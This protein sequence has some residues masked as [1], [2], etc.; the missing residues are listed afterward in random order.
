MD[1][2]KI[3][4]FQS[5]EDDDQKDREFFEDD[6]DL[7][8]G[9]TPN[10]QATMGGFG[11]FGPAFDEIFRQNANKRGSNYGG[12]DNTGG[13]GGPPPSGGAP[14]R[15][16]NKKNNKKVVIALILLAISVGFGL[17]LQYYVDFQWFR[18]LDFQEIFIKQIVIQVVAA[19]GVFI[20]G[21]LL[22]L[23]IA[24]LFFKKNIVAGGMAKKTFR[25]IALAGSAVAGFLA[26]SV[27][28]G[29]FS[30]QLLLFLNGSSFQEID[31]I[32]NQD[33]SFYVFTL[34]FMQQIYNILLML[35][36]LYLVAG[37]VVYFKNALTS[38]AKDAFSPQL[39]TLAGFFSILWG[40]GYWFRM[41]DLLYGSGGVVFGATYTDIH[42]SLPF[43]RIMT[44]AMIGLG[45]F[46]IV[47]KNFKILK[48]AFIGFVAV[49][50]LST[51][52]T[53]AVQA[54]IVAPNELQM[55]KEYI[56]YNIDLTR[57]AYSL[58]ETENID[59]P[60]SDTLTEEMIEDNQI[61]IDNVRINDPTPANTVYNQIQSFK[62]YYVFN[63][64]DI[65]RYTFDDEYRQVF[66]SGRELNQANLEE[67]AK[68]WQNLKLKY[69]HGYGVVMSP[70]STVTDQGRPDFI[71][72][73][74]PPQSDEIEITRPEIYYGELTNDYIITNTSIPEF[75]YAAGDNDN[76][77]GFYEGDGGINL[78]FF[79]KL[80]MAIR[81]QDINIILSQAIDDDSKIHLYRN[82]LERVNKIA[83]FIDWTNDP[84]LTIV[85]GKL[86]WMVDGFTATDL[87]PYATPLITQFG[88]LN[89]INNSVKAVVDAYNGDVTFYA[90]NDAD[91]IIATW[92]NIYPESFKDI[93]E[94]PD[95]MKDHIMYPYELFDIQSFQYLDY[96][97]TSAD[98]FYNKADSWDIA[99]E[100][101][102]TE[103]IIMESYYA[104]M[105]IS[106][107]RGLEYLLTIP[108]TPADKS[109]MNGLMV[110]SCDYENYGKLTVL[111]LPK[112]TTIYGPM[113]IE[114]AI[115]QDPDISKELTL[116]GQQGSNVIR[117]NMM[118]IP[119]GDTLIYVE[120]I[121]LEASG[122]NSLPEI[123]RVIVAHGENVVMEEDFETALRKI[124]ELSSGSTVDPSEPVDPDEPV[125]PGEPTDPSEPVDPDLTATEE[126]L[127]A[128]SV[129]L[130]EQ[131]QA[132]SQRGD[133]TAYGQYLEALEAVL[134]QL[135][136]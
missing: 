4:Q 133:W 65:D 52:V 96:H 33:V 27:M 116:W 3:I 53:Y 56:E 66:I 97:M 103:E 123:Q 8:S 78:S 28:G 55:E 120:P 63:D 101:Y 54:W 69:T 40:G 98:V 21:F 95:E 22:T 24:H 109:V 89:Y 14:Q 49:T 12:G 38:E 39:L 9:E 110:A 134:N 76:V 79:N 45:I 136:N 1:D 84:Y 36:G 130:L 115:D 80:M 58:D 113:Q 114:N 11:L 26:A 51:A 131:A 102:Y 75:N 119:V 73:D 90:F 129:Q 82:V 104:S 70:I 67:D 31:P 25:W 59:Y 5:K 19:V 46:L 85:D 81:L 126:E 117:G 2:K 61:T 94:M 93:S 125:D 15:E 106:E 71:V 60:V 88:T 105:E 7:E 124:V 62:P 16:W 57:K 17:I 41:Y 43:Y 44:F 107:D 100:K 13:T 87:Y 86:Y 47:A 108:F 83:P 121:Y 35:F 10:K 30:T 34:P 74:I 99:K 37:L 48:F 6:E 29:Q 64:I 91:P 118:T 122:S 68:T 50:I 112:V 92:S 18:S 111:N 32:F 127:I 72:Q 42:I 132:A 77:E 135:A 128:Q 20:V 23:L